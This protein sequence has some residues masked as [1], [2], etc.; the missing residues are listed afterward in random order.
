[1]IGTR[2]DGPTALS[3]T[4]FRRLV[5]EPASPELLAF[6]RFRGEAQGAGPSTLGSQEHR[7]LQSPRFVQTQGAYRTFVAQRSEAVS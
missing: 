7:K 4:P 6:L 5:Q 2:I 3:V 1:M